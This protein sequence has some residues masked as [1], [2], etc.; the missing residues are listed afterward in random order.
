MK[1]YSVITDVG[2]KRKSNQDNYYVGENWCIVADG[3]GGHKGGE[4][5]SRCAIE[6]IKTNLAQQAFGVDS[7]LKGAI[8][9][10]N[11]ALYNMSINDPSLE[12]MGTTAVLCYFEGAV[13]YVAHVG[14]SR[15]YHLTE[16]GLRQLTNDHSIVQQLI[17]SGTITP[18]EAK[19]HPQ[20]N[21]ITRAIGTESTI[22]VDVCTVNIKEGDYILLCTDGLTSFVSDSEIEAV[23]KAMGLDDAVTKLVNMA[24]SSGG[25]DNITIVLIKV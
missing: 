7:L 23:V 10:A 11:K 17:E 19:T 8:A 12:G 25:T 3:M 2:R 21:L 14:D 13:A 1:N 18:K 4:T 5:A 16:L 20:K 15:A 22:D 6:I 9:D 24:N